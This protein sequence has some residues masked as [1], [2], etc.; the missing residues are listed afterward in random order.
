MKKCAELAFDK[1]YNLFSLG[2]YGL[3]LSGKDASQRYSEKGGTG[4][5]K[6]DHGIG[7]GGAMYVY[8]FGKEFNFSNDFF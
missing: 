1:G 3:C 2:N 6:C 8:T 7:R 4:A 5:D